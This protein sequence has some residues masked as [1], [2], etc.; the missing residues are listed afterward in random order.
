MRRYTNGRVYNAV[1][2]TTVV[3]VA[4]LAVLMVLTTSPPGLGL[5]I[6]GLDV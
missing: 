5:H 1:A 3:A 4:G 6:L 2:W